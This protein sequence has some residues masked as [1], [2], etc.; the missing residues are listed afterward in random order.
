M[1]ICAAQLKPEIGARA[2]NHKA[3]I[4]FIKQAAKRETDII[5]FPELS[6]TGYD[7]ALAAKMV[8]DPLDSFF[9]EYHSLSTQYNITI[10]LG[11]PTKNAG[12]VNISML[13]FEPGKAVQVY[14]KQHLHA[15]ELPYFVAGQ[16]AIN[17][18]IA[19]L[20]IAP[21]ICYESLLPEHV[22]QAVQRGA[23]FYMTSVAKSER[24]VTKA[25]NHYPKIARQYGIPVL[26]VN[27]IGPAEDFIS[28]GQSAVWNKAGELRGKL[29]A[30]CEGLLVYNTETDTVY[31]E[32][33]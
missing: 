18:N 12:G 31:T 27:N 7:S 13:I 1:K 14:S 25:F 16:Q 30:D 10:A 4:A 19:N 24:G 21:A 11:A 5:V 29:P 26:M 17:L 28:A 9:D 20:T 2:E 8:V 22:A 3:H 6:L 23:N 15:D 32:A 33:F